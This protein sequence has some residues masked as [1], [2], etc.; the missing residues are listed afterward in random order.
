[1]Y[2]NDFSSMTDQQV[3][4]AVDNST[5]NSVTVRLSNDIVTVG[6][7]EM[8]QVDRIESTGTTPLYRVRWPPFE[9]TPNITVNPLLASWNRSIG[10]PANEASQ[11]EE[12]T[13]DDAE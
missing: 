9:S 3:G 1:M 8:V 5:S 13:P 4:I 11:E 6:S 2:L 10:I 7:D 12:A